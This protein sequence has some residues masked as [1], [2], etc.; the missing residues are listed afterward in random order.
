M[1]FNFGKEF[2]SNRTKQEELH[3]KP[4]NTVEK[5]AEDFKENQLNGEDLYELEKSEFIDQF[6]GK[7]WLQNIFPVPASVPYPTQ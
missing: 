6:K 1:D 7:F 2:D 3:T 5:F 4:Q